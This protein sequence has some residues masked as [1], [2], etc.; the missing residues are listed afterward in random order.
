MVEDFR[1]G[2]VLDLQGAAADVGGEVL[3]LDT[4]VLEEGVRLA[5]AAQVGL[6]TGI[7]SRCTQ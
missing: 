3:R 1:H 4:N 7:G 6:K 5:P 2:R